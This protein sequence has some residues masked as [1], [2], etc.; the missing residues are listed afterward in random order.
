MI[1][2]RSTHRRGFLGRVAAAAVAL[3]LPWSRLEA[4]PVAAADPSDHD[5]WLDGL[6]GKYR[7]LF[8]SPAP[9]DNLPPLHMLNYL[10]TYNSA[11]GVPDQ[12]VNAVGTF[13]GSVTLYGVNDAM[14]AKYRIGEFQKLN[15][16]TGQ[17]LARS[18]WRGEVHALG[19][20]IP[21]ASIEALQKRGV[22][23]ILCNNA[24]NLFSDMLAKARGL[25]T[26]AVY[27][28][29]KANLLPGVVLVPAMVIAIEKAQGKGLAYRRE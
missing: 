19:M 4:R 29:L 11:Y 17:P 20:V 18:P 7:Q 9:A 23:F 27:E 13:Y 26:K 8:D 21:A 14:W 5:K 22:V 16:A 28:D 6:K 2:P 25:E 1:D 24:L 10:N 3:G 12:E 15:D